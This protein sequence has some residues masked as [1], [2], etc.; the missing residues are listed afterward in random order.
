LRCPH[1]LAGLAGLS[2]YLPL[3][4]STDAQ[5]SA[6]NRDVPVFLAH[7]TRDGVVQ[8]GRGVASRMALQGLGYEV[9][10]HEYPM[11]HSVCMEEVQAL[12]AWLL[13][14]LA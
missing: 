14:V 7:G 11:E 2:G 5:R 6:A 10:W 1:R 8:L 4:D 12:Q 3:A 9:E 13:K